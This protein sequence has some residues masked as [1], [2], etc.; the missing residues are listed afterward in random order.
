MPKRVNRGSAPNARAMTTSK[1]QV[2]GKPQSG[3]FP[4]ASTTG[5]WPSYSAVP[6]VIRRG[7]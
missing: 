2:R 6:L 5:R 7:A 1:A 3:M 4:N